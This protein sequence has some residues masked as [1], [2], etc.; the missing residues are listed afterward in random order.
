M[1]RA[2]VTLVFRDLRVAKSVKHVIAEGTPHDDV[3][4]EFD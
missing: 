1:D 4:I 3:L 2:P